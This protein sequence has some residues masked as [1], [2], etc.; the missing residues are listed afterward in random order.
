MEAKLLLEDENYIASVN[1]YIGECQSNLSKFCNINLHSLVK[2]ASE[3][4]IVKLDE[5]HVNEYIWD[6]I[7]IK[8]D[9]APSNCNGKAVVSDNN[10][11][12][13]CKIFRIKALLPTITS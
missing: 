3:V 6:L 8:W 13:W 10:C 1:I 9:T 2:G 7:P 11:I 4:N 12:K 5:P